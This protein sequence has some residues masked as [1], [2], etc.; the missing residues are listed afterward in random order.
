MER[1][2]NKRAI[3]FLAIGLILVIIAGGWY[4]YNLVEDNNA[5]KQAAD[6]L[7]KLEANRPPSGD[8]EAAPVIVV[9][10]DAFCGKVIIDKLG[11]ELPVYDEWDY[12]RLKSAPCRYMGSI[13]DDDIVIAGHNYKSHFGPL[14]NLKNGDEIKFQDAFGTIYVYEVRELVTLDG[15]AVSDMQSGGWDFTLFTCNMSGEQR[16]TVRCER[17]N[18]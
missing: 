4:A 2:T 7:D 15:T 8:V 18:Q 6:L 11:I 13:A 1:K 14:D 17:K 10:G 16:V 9:D 12:N 3:V 5:G